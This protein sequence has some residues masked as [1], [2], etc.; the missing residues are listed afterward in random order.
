MD[1]QVYTLSEAAKRLRLTNRGVAKIA[2]RYG[3][4]MIS[5]R[6]ITLTESDIE[7]IKQAL[8]AIPK[9]PRSA[10]LKPPPSDYQLHK[11]LVELSRK[12]VSPKARQIALQRSNRPSAKR[13]LK[14]EFGE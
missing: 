6:V 10:P 8:R 1:D 7:G 13:M 4:C 11:R 9:D 5:G 3:L 12:T 2:R 14:E